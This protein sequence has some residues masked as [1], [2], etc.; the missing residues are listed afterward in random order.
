MNLFE[1][2]KEYIESRGGKMISSSAKYKENFHWI[3]NNN[4]NNFSCMQMLKRKSWCKDCVKEKTKNDVIDR[5]NALSYKL[6]SYS[7]QKCIY[8]CNFG[9]EHSSTASH[10]VNG[11]QCGICFKNNKRKAYNK[12]AKK[13]VEDRLK[14]YGFIFLDEEYKSL[15]T[16]HKLQCKND[17]IFKKELVHL[18]HGVVGC[19]ECNNYFASERNFRKLIEN[20]IKKPFP[21]KRPNWLINP[22]TGYKLELDCYNEELKIAFEYDGHFHF[23]IRK[24]LNNNLEKTKELDF[25]KNKLCEQNGIKLIRIPYFL[26]EDQIKNIVI[27]EINNLY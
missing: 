14:K 10:I 27:K 2:V 5:L 1:K 15:N 8:I 9:H 11:N 24:G 13:E 22:K 6:V 23:E 26:K 16:K 19:P 3:C 25:I 17:H 20:I 21:K 18:I 7:S 12:L 4:H